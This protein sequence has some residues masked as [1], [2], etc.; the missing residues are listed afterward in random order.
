MYKCNLL[1]VTIFSLLLLVSCDNGKEDKVQEALSAF[2]EVLKPGEYAETAPFLD[3]NLTSSVTMEEWTNLLK[4]MDSFGKV[5]S[6]TSMNVTVGKYEGFTEAV[7][8][9]EV[10]RSEQTLYA[11]IVLI[12]R[13]DG[14]KIEGYRYATSLE[15]LTIDEDAEVIAIEFY[16]D[17]KNG[18]YEKISKLMSE[19]LRAE[20]S[21]EQLVAF[22]EKKEKFG[23]L[24]S[25]ER[26]GVQSNGVDGGIRCVF[27]Y[28]VQHEEITLY[29]DLVLFKKDGQFYIEDY[30]YFANR[31][32]RHAHEEEGNN[33][34]EV[35]DAFFVALEHQ[36]PTE[37]E[38]LL[39]NDAGDPA[40][41]FQVMAEKEAVTGALQ[42]H[43]LLDSYHKPIEG[44]EYYIFEYHTE[45]EN[46]HLYE[47]L[48]LDK[49]GDTYKVISY[50]YN[51]DKDKVF[52]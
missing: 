16:E 27:D 46:L 2:Y 8:R 13:E 41:W 52:K 18:E 23:K 6:F 48:I 30:E 32:K 24:L 3:E 47:K 5:E 1:L 43:F 31:D 21:E 44:R 26:T 40:K 50:E 9:Y 39:G 4:Q 37:L 20:V 22:L 33:A 42:K 11:E 17:C 49:E 12:E 51:Q 7:A 19:S 36:D 29:E 38:A 28:T 15:M 45:Y 34:D 14:F 10:T 25:Y 35:A